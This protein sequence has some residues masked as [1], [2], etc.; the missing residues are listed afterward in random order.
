VSGI[1]AQR[2]PGAIP[3]SGKPKASS[4]RNPHP[5]H[6]NRLRGSSFTLFSLLIAPQ[7]KGARDAFRPRSTRYFNH[8]FVMIL[9]E[10]LSMGVEA[11]DHGQ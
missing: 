1:S 10:D 7:R 5:S 8:F 11:H 3:W 4:Y 9:F 2:V 6:M